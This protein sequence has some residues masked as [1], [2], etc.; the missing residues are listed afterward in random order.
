[1][2]APPRRQRHLRGL[3]YILIGQPKRLLGL[4]DDVPTGM[5]VGWPVVTAC[6][7]VAAVWVSRGARGE[8]L[9]ALPGA[10]PRLR[11]CRGLKANIVFNC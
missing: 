9:A 5:A 8:R 2:G 10:R 3:H 1:M 4:V 7:I 11:R 6:C